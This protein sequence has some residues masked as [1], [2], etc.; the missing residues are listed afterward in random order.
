MG[1]TVKREVLVLAYNVTILIKS[2]VSELATA[3]NHPEK[4]TVMGHVRAWNVVFLPT[5]MFFYMSIL[6]TSAKKAAKLK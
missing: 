4:W 3:K 6:H 1:K 2:G 5:I